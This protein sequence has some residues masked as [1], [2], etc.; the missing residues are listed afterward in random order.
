MLIITSTWTALRT[1]MKAFQPF[2]WCQLLFC[3]GWYKNNEMIVRLN[4]TPA[5]ISGGKIFF[6]CCWMKCHK[7][8]EHTQPDNEKHR[9][10]SSSF[11]DYSFKIKLDVHSSFFHP[12]I[13]EQSK[14]CVYNEKKK[15][16]V[17]ACSWHS[18]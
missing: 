11:T 5:V 12:S 8:R 14:F 3:N 10:S 16:F 1:G 4:T 7:N 15:P 9:E 13:N 18:S 17:H 6:Y 2:D